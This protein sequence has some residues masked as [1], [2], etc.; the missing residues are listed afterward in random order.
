MSNITT[1]LHFGHD[2][3][4]L[5][6]TVPGTGAEADK[7]DQFI[8]QY[9]PEFLIYILGYPLY[10]LLI[11][12]VGDGGIYDNLKNGETFTDQLGLT[13]KWDGFVEGKN[14]IACYIY[15]QY[16]KS[17]ASNT[18]GVGE[19]AADV[20]N[21]KRIS[22]KGK[23]VAAWNKMVECNNLLH[24]YLFAKRT[25][26][27]TYIGLQYPPVSQMNSRS[28]D[29]IKNYQKLFIKINNYNI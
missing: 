9:E 14:P 2:P 13:R 5:P 1:Y 8:K 27:P 6:N 12:N 22:P 23:M 7:I 16:Q 26:Y 11:N 21:G 10:N 28:P 24:E 20:E 17:N 18:Y 19:S 3:I 15:Y 29:V 25:F 4:V